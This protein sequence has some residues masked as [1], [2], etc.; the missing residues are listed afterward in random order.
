[1]KTY[2][3]TV[4]VLASACYCVLADEATTLASAENPCAS[5][6]KEDEKRLNVSET[7]VEKSG[8]KPEDMPHSEEDFVKT[9][10][11]KVNRNE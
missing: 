6:F 8:L 2:I 3:V 1:M 4:L 7:C 9:F 5:K 10:N 11:D